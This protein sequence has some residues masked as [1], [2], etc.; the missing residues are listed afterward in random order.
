MPNV[1]CQSCGRME[2]DDAFSVCHACVWRR[3][4]RDDEPCPNFA[5]WP[6]TIC[7]RCVR[8]P[9]YAKILDRL[10]GRIIG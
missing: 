1:L 6:A 8:Q 2:H 7:H 10:T 4:Q 3:C 9:W 5:L